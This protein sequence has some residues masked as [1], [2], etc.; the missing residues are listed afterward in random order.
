LCRKRAQTERQTKRTREGPGEERRRRELDIGKGR[1]R[2][3]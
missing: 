3:E 1:E 2:I